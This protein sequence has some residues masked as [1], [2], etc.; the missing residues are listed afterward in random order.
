MP[1]SC[2]VWNSRGRLINWDIYTWKSLYKWM[3][4]LRHAASSHLIRLDWMSQDHLKIGITLRWS[5]VQ[6]R[7]R[8][9]VQ[10][11]YVLHFSFKWET[12]KCAQGWRQQVIRNKPDSSTTNSVDLCCWKRKKMMF[13]GRYIWLQKETKYIE[14]CISLHETEQEHKSINMPV[15]NQ[16]DFQYPLSNC[17]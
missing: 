5:E 3:A 12:E 1:M 16:T 4:A 15:E 8:I 13:F 14:H 6:R 11:Q 2:S 17:K 7:N 9:K 10:Q